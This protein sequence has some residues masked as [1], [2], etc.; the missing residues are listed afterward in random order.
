MMLWVGRI[1]LANVPIYCEVKLLC[2]CAKCLQNPS[3]NSGLEWYIQLTDLTLRHAPEPASIEQV[4]PMRVTGAAYGY[5]TVLM[6]TWL[7]LLSGCTQQYVL[8]PVLMQVSRTCKL[9]RKMGSCIL[10][11][12]STCQCQ[13][14]LFSQVKSVRCLSTKLC[15]QLYGISIS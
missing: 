4:Y 13:F 12:Q 2:M 3:P 14:M 1:A 10:K 15:F 9:T 7:Q 5:T 11:L 8:K 6:T